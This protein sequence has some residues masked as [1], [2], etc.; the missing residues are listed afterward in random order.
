M[1]GWIERINAALGSPR[2]N[3]LLSI[4]FITVG[5]IAILV[6]NSR[7]NHVRVNRQVDQQVDRLTGEGI[8]RAVSA[9]GQL[10]SLVFGSDALASMPRARVGLWVYDSGGDG[11]DGSDGLDGLDQW[12]EF[13]AYSDQP[14]GPRVVVLVHG[15]D[16]PGG[17]WDDLAPKLSEAG[18]VVVRFDYANDQAISMSAGQCVR[19]L[20]MLRDA[21]VER[22]DFVCHSMGG[23]VVRDAIT[24]QRFV[25]GDHVVGRLITIGT[26]HG[27]SPWA[28]LRAVAEMREQVQRFVEAD[29]MD[30]MQLLGFARDGVGQAGRD[31]LPE[32]EFFVGLNERGLD[33][34]IK[35]TCIVGRVVS[36]RGVEIGSVLAGGV[37]GELI[38]VRDVEFIGGEL[39]KINAGLGD[40]VVSMSSAVL[41]GVEDV[42]ILEA[43][44]RGLV[45]RVELEEAIRKVGGVRAADEP[46]AIEV[47]LDRLTEE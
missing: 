27:G 29:E 4:V 33:D 34:S 25:D 23:L 11:S 2:R 26:P 35:V 42:V 37:M 1:S 32:S 10:L 36:E 8:S 14:I 7:V 30:P 43:N 3:L 47:V 16:E 21:G 19:S 45:R 24:R 44:H 41:D 12:I 38:G 40:G 18:F 46:P 28:R 22:V 31:L 13:G 20:E 15:L 9:S 5:L 17:I 6:G 39:E